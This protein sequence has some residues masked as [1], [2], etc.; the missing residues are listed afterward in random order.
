M[1]RKGLFLGASLLL[2]IPATQAAP[3]VTSGDNNARIIQVA[4]ANGVPAHQS[5]YV[6]V[7]DEVEPSV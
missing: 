4:T 7:P 2:A 5:A 6:T 1:I 3:A